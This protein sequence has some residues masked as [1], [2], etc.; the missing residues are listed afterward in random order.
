M[1]KETAILICSKN[2]VTELALLLQSLRTSTYQDF[3]IF[4]L[5]DKSDNPNEKY[6]FFNCLINALKMEGHKVFIKYNEFC[7]GVNKARQ[8]IVDWALESNYK[9]LCR[10][11]DDVIIESDYL[12]KLVNV[13][14]QG[15]DFA[16]GVTVPMFQSTFIRDPIYLKG[17]ANR[18]ILKEGKIVYNGDD[19]GMRYTDSIIVPCDHFRSCGLYKSEIHKKAN[20]MPTRLS[21][22]GFREE[23]IFSF[24][25]I[26]N[27]FKI[28]CDTG[29]INY[30]Q[31]TPSGGE[32]PTM[33]MV[34]FNQ[35]ILEEETKEL[36]DKYGDFIKD[37]HNRLGIE[38]I[39][40][41]KEYQKENNTCR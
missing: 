29:A 24:R 16:T 28:G 10:L 41:D 11:D 6:H 35:N 38:E 25:M 17:I 20:Y 7:Y 2:R 32:R 5:D 33:N 21:M 23:Q 36:F 34:P 3:D 1:V 18:V 22:N 14:N 40:L 37:Y 19:C 8:A 39:E 30:H 31:I 4:I 26:V 13:I 9:Y 12:N 15:Y 27:G